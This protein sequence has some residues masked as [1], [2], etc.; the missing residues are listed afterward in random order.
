MRKPV[1]GTMVDE[2]P[3]AS[4]A[5]RTRSMGVPGGIL[6]AALKLTT[7]FRPRKEARGASPWPV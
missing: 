6:D 7:P 1:T 4:S 2:F 5:T 3:A